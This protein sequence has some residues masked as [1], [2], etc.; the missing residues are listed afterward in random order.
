MAKATKRQLHPGFWDLVSRF[1]FVVKTQNE[2]LVLV[3]MFV[4][5]VGVLFVGEKTTLAAFNYNMFQDQKSIGKSGL[6]FSYC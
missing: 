2:A 4:A 3:N 5:V 1:S 6:V